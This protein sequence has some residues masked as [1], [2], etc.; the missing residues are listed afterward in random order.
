M[1]SEIMVAAKRYMPKLPIRKLKVKK[2]EGI[3][4]RCYRI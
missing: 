4:P 3:K 1:S 2:A